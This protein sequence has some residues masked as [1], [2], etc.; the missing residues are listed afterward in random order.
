[1]LSFFSIVAAPT[2]NVSEIA[3]K[4]ENAVASQI[5]GDL[6]FFGLFM[7]ADIIVKLVILTLIVFSL[8]SWAVIFAKTLSFSRLKKSMYKFEDKFW[9]G[10]SLQEVFV[11]IV[12]MKVKDPLSSMFISMMK[13][14]D[15]VKT[16]DNS[17][18]ASIKERV[19][20]SS[21]IAMNKSVEE[22]EEGVSI[23]ATIANSAPFIGLFGTVWGIMHSFQ[24]IAANKDTSLAVVAPGIAEALFAT[25]IGLA[26]AIPAAIFY[27]KLSVDINRM[28]NKIENFAMEVSALL[29]RN[30]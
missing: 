13:E 1:M 24:S 10:K 28:H 22:L 29:I 18:V 20:L 4:T 23:L 8:V 19:S 14:I 9:S 3:I 7:Q 5:G 17:S 11:K 25:A 6:S 26:V 21:R 30:I 16:S 2:D 27:N 12:D 15:V